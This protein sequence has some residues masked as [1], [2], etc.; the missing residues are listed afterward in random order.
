[1]F[2]HD[3]SQFGRG[4]DDRPT[5]SSMSFRQ[6]LPD[7]VLCNLRIYM[8]Q[9]IVS[10]QRCVRP[11]C[12]QPLQSIALLL[13][14]TSASLITCQLR[15][16]FNRRSREIMSS[17]PS[18][19]VVQKLGR[20]T[21]SSLSAYFVVS[22]VIQPCEHDHSESGANVDVQALIVEIWTRTGTLT[23]SRHYLNTSIAA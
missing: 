12:L 21:S 16:I 6:S 15:P 19:N 13:P 2:S 7:T 17:F 23:T 22:A 4:S 14:R 18:K 11:S 1:M 9:M 20:S 3:F 8:C 5:R 10:H